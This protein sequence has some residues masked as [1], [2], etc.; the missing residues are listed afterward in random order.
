MDF[1]VV[2]SRVIPGTRVP[3]Y[4]AAGV[5]K[6]SFLKFAMLTVLSVSAWVFIAL[7]FGNK[8][9]SVFSDHFYLLVI[10]NRQKDILCFKKRVVT[11]SSKILLAKVAPF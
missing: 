1:A 11:Q 6:Y 8:F 3:T 4:F 2:I 10:F 9:F 7:S 5:S